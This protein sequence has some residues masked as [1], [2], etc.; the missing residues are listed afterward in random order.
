MKEGWA[1]RPLGE[2]SKF[3]GGG[4]PSKHN[5]SFWNG[6]IPWVSPKDMKFD[7]IVESQDKITADAIENSAAKMIPEGSI[8]IVV[9]SGI[10][11]RTIPIGL[12]GRPLAINQDL[13][14]I[15]PKKGLDRSYLRYF[16]LANEDLLLSKVSRGATVHRL[17][18]E[19]L[20]ALP[21]PL[22]SLEEQKRIV[23]VLDE[24]FEGLAR[25][26]ANAEANLQNARELFDQSASTIIENAVEIYPKEQLADVTQKITKGSSPKWQGI[27]YVKSPGVLFVTSENVGKNELIFEKTKY[28]E[29]AFNKKDRKSI[30]SNGD[31]LTNIV[32][33]S[34]GRTAVF[35]RNDVANINQ[36]V[37]L[38]RCDP[39]KLV[40][41]FLCF[42]LNSPYF[43][44]ALH[45]GEV[46]MARA[47][48][49]LTF[50]RELQVPI[51]PIR[52]QE[53]Y[54]QKMKD[55]SE[56]VGELETAFTTKLDEL[57]RLK[58]SLLQKAFAGELT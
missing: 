13:K 15:V 57:E 37:C 24:A 4:T 9:R 42:L 50:F 17:S 30:L 23:A 47:N 3:V 8:L 44:R 58:Q 41:Y 29:S 18:T 33:A 27:Q 36:A 20:K 35:D 2:V 38:I 55:I 53:M 49:S 26:R 48:L 1:V 22:P 11:A 34:I 16:F 12:T 45:A 31:V 54:V 56:K 51:P 5:A 39:D 10:L 19:D 25:A 46:N 43:K 52:Q 40:N 21:V 6:E 14:A 28:V 32:G 7:T